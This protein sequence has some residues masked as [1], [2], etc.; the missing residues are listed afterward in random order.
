ML[1][2]VAFAFAALL[3]H[4]IEKPIRFGR[5]SAPKHSLTLIG[6]ML[7]A[8]IGLT[9]FQIG[10]EPSKKAAEKD[11]SFTEII[12]LA[13]QRTA[14]DVIDPDGNV[15]HTYFS[16][17]PRREPC[18]LG[19]E[20]SNATV[21]LIGDSH[22]QVFVFPLYER[23]EEQALRRLKILTIN[24]C[25]WMGPYVVRKDD[26]EP[27]CDTAASQARL[28]QAM[29]RAKSNCGHDGTVSTLS[30]WGAI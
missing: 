10:T 26:G 16:D 18:V 20:T 9:S 24:S 17:E 6:I 29:G 1:L 28:D 7:V 5:F 13:K 8:S 22:A 2:I 23:L 19:S 12:E 14:D 3:H 30:Q 27:I 4:L 15:C 11:T 25:A 21:S